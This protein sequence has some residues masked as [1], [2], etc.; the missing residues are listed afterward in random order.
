M[1]V[2]K[3]IMKKFP[4]R[5]GQNQAIR[6]LTDDDEL[7]ETLIAGRDEYLEFLE[8]R[9]SAILNDEVYLFELYNHVCEEIEKAEELMEKPGWEDLDF[10]ITKRNLE[11][12]MSSQSGNDQRDEQWIPFEDK[13]MSAVE[14]AE[15]TGFTREY[16]V[17]LTKKIKRK[18][19]VKFCNE[20]LRDELVQTASR[21]P[22][23][24]L[25]L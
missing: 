23:K 1:N 11:A 14:M 13:K 21:I 20:G 7:Y 6:T 12:L 18:V 17:N 25:T 4:T 24:P 15:V 9:E 3:E 10:H 8:E 2:L 19:G 5:E 16:I 22:T